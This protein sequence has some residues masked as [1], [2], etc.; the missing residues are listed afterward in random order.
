MV[1]RFNFN[2]SYFFYPVYRD[3]Y[4]LLGSE[5]TAIE[6]AKENG[7]RNLALLDATKWQREKIDLKRLFDMSAYPDYKRNQREIA[8]KQGFHDRDLNYRSEPKC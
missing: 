3:A 8:R 6:K 7:R 5:S 4:E 1:K 2:G